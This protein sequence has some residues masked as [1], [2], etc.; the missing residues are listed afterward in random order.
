MYEILL[1]TWVLDVL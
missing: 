1:E